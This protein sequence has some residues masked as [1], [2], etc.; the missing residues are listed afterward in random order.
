MVAHILLLKIDKENPASFS[1]IVITDILRNYL[2]YDGVVITDDMT[3]GAVVKNYDIGEAAVKSLNAGSDII[4]VCHDFDK[5]TAVLNSINSAVQNKALTE[6]SID[7][8]VYRILKLKQKYNI[9][10]EKINS[11]NVKAINEKINSLVKDNFK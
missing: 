1:K 5:E 6:K 10:D 2:K 4:L 8:K 11:I 7:E 3:M 9:K